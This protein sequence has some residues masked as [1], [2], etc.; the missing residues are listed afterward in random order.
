[1]AESS[2]EIR[3]DSANKLLRITLRGHWSS[4]TVASY[5]QALSVAVA[6]MVQRGCRRAELV[7]LV[8]ARGVGAQPLAV[9]EEY[10]KSFRS[11]DMQPCRLAT[12]VSSSLFRLQIKRIAVPNQR[13][14]T[15]ETDAT[16]WLLAAGK[17][18]CDAAAGQ[19]APPV[20]DKTDPRRE[21]GS[22]MH[23]HR[24]A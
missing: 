23:Q 11:P 24:L 4:D 22:A 8:D 6:Q 17:P 16:Q 5:K 10:R 19:M 2:F 3:T 1:M 7:A 20:D 21:D 12:T 9:I 15:D 18:D 14:F 13:I